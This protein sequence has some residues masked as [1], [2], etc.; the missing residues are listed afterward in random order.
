MAEHTTSIDQTP[1]WRALQR[2]HEELAG[3]QLR[4]LFAADPGRGEAM[5]CEAGD[6]Y[7]DWSKHR[8]TVETVRLLVA[9]AERAGLRERIDARFAGQ[10]IYTT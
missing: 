6:L 2:H 1:E 8:V 5:T 3:A 4:E 9:L 10:R 7:L